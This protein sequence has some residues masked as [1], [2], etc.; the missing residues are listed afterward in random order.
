MLAMA[1]QTEPVALKLADSIEDARWIFDPNEAEQIAREDPS[2]LISRGDLD[3]LVG[4]LSQSMRDELE[5]VYRRESGSI[6][7][8]DREPYMWVR[9]VTRRSTVDALAAR[10][11]IADGPYSDYPVGGYRARLGTLGFAV[12]AWLRY[13]QRDLRRG[14]RALATGEPLDA[15]PWVDRRDHYDR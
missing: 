10:G 12:R 8:H 1:E 2:L 7:E 15:D 9:F 3:V 14:V 5:H 13:Q 6:H 11:L 4:K